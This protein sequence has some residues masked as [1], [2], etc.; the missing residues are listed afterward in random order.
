MQNPISDFDPYDLLLRL[1]ANQENLIEN[2]NR[3]ASDYEK[4]L[5]RLQECE[6]RIRHLQNQIRIMY[7]LSGTVQVRDDGKE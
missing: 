6:N 5:L 4:N 1:A 2:H 3:L 7:G